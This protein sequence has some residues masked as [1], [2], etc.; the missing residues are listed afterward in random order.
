MNP[1]SVLTIISSWLTE[2]QWSLSRTEMQGAVGLW[3]S[4]GSYEGDA[5]P[6]KEAFT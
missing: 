2:Y 3:Q 5:S 4:A 6:G 1:E